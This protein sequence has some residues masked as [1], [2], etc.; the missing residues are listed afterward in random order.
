MRVAVALAFLTLNACVSSGTYEKKEAEAKKLAEEVKAEQV[1]RTE[2]QS[3]FD[4]VQKDL[5]ALSNDAT[6]LRERLKA[7]EEKL[8]STQSELQRKESELAGLQQKSSE[9]EKM[10][11]AL[12]SQID[13][14][15]VELSELRGRM[16]VKL[17]D[18]ILFSSGSAKVGKEGREA[19]AAVAGVLAGVQNKVIRVEGHTDDVPTGGAYPTNWEL[20][21]ARALAVVRF[22]QSQGI[23]PTRLA[24]AGYGEFRPIAPNDTPE[25][26]SKNRRIEIV[27]ASPEDAPPA[28]LAAPAGGAPAAPR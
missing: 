12:K 10:A 5:D 19:L 11:Q 9:Y 21:A 6:A 22:L 14:G 25:G 4:A 17:K 18:R 23:D 26:R 24:A 13:T 2:L 20:S 7:H 8:T 3:R 16:T 28:E 1:R 27:L 15:R